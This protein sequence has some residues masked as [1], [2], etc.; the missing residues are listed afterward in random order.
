MNAII[1][2]IEHNY[3]PYLLLITSR[4]HNGECLQDNP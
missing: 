4:E 1:F 2:V 3:P